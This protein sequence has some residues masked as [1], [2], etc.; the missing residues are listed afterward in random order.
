MIIFSLYVSIQFSLQSLRLAILA[1]PHRRSTKRASCILTNGSNLGLKT[2]GVL[3]LGSLD[4]ILA[5]M[6]ACIYPIMGTLIH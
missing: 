1:S 2:C 4:R 3:I 6:W 5:W